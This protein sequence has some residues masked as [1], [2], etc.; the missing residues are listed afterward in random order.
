VWTGSANAYLF[1]VIDACDRDIVGNIFSDRCCAREAADAL[2]GAVLSR[3]GGRV[4][5]DH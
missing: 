5:Y 2:E 4:P 1:V 3:F